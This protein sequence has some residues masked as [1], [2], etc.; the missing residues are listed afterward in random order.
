ME[1]GDYSV[2]YK[3]TGL[4]KDVGTIVTKRSQLR[5]A[6]LDALHDAGVEILTPTVMNQRVLPA[7]QPVIPATD[8]RPE[9][10][11]DGGQAERIMFDKAELAARI[12]RFR[13][14]SKQLRE[15]IARLEQENAETNALEIA[16]RKHQVESLEELI[17]EVD[18]NDG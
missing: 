7:E 16:W 10:P 8:S 4:L 5:G 14:Q 15:E 12:E 1:I 18:D 11:A 9:L 13:E 3:I 6:V 17:A 2:R